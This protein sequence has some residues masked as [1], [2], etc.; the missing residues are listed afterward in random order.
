MKKH[1]LKNHYYYTKMGYISINK[2]R[3]SIKCIGFCRNK[4]EFVK[5]I[6]NEINKCIIEELSPQKVYWAFTHKFFINIIK[7]NY[8]VKTIALIKIPFTERDVTNLIEY[9]E[10]EEC[11]ECNKKECFVP[12]YVNDYRRGDL[13]LNIKSNYLIIFKLIPN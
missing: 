7:K 3:K 8:N 12:K 6:K 13:K 2:D 10:C 11:S 1:I 5:T 4:K 9:W